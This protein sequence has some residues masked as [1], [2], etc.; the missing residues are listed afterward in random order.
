M[1]GDR[2]LVRG[3]RQVPKRR[4]LGAERDA[5]LRVDRRVRYSLYA[6]GIRT[7]R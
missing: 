1:G 5:Q 3:L 4:T 7:A 2:K 6:K